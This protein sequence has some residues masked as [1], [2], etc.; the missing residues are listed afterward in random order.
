MDLCGQRNVF[1]FWYTVQV[2]HD[3]FAK[4]KASFNFMAEVTICNNFGAQENKVW[5]CFHCF[6][7][8]PWS[9][10]TRFHDFVY[11]MLSFKPAFSFSS[12]T[13]IKRFFSSSLLSAHKGSIIC[14]SEVIDISPHNLDSSLCFIQPGILDNVHCILNKQGDS[15]QLWCTPFPVWNQTI[16][17]CPV[18]T[19][20]SWP[21]CKFLRRQVGWSGIPIS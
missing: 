16:V 10:G 1:A 2:P 12:F 18:L 6:P 14:I 13:L 20:A 5:H 11:W 4:E 3:F 15:I 8:L 17:P 21:A 7:C 9:D 19:V